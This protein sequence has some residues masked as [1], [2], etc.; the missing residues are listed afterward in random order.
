MNVRA[1]T[2]VVAIMLLGSACSDPQAY[3]GTT[4]ATAAPSSTTTIAVAPTN[5]TT[6]TL[7]P[8]PIRVV[9]IGDFGTGSSEQYAVAS[10][11]EAMAADDPIAALVTTGDNFYRDDIELIWLDPYGWVD[12]TG[13]PIHAAWGNH[14]IETRPRIEL[15]AKHLRP[16]YR[17]YASELGEATLVVIDSNQVE[18]EDQLAWLEETL[19]ASEGLIIVSFHHPAFACGHHGS[20]GSVIET[21]VPLFEDTGSIS[22]STA[23]STAMSGSGSMGS[24]I[25]SPEAQVRSC[26]TS[27][28]VRRGRRRHSA[29]M[30][31]ATILCCSRLA[32]TRST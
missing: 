21:W 18:N 22:F 19:A 20:T 3:S 12:E 23:T 11:I 24:P 8:D 10:L 15:V 9:V 7:A 5:A 17:W 16:P 13:V 28:R 29:G 31:I 30:T 32:R 14:D 2:V 25:S 4:I 26:G 6:T 1:F 27:G